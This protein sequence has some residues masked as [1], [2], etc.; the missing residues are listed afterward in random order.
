LGIVYSIC[1][2]AL[3]VRLSKLVAAIRLA[4]AGCRFDNCEARS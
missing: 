4:V 1:L 2:D 3:S